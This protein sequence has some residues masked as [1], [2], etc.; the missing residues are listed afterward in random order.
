[1][2]L[3]IYIY[4]EERTPKLEKARLVCEVTTWNIVGE[5]EL[6]DQDRQYRN[7]DEESIDQGSAE[8]EGTRLPGH[9]S[10][11]SHEY[12]RFRIRFFRKRI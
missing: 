7:D 8:E 2:M 11:D 3:H 12:S 1:M 9:R 5:T 4:L 6:Q 10:S